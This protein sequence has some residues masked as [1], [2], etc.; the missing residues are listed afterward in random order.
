M[1]I[2]IVKP[3]TAT[4]S[5]STVLRA[6]QRNDDG[7]GIVAITPEGLDIRRGFG[8]DAD[9]TLL[10]AYDALRQY[11][12]IIH[13]RIGTTGAL[14]LRNTHPFPIAHDAWLFHNGTIEIDRNAAPEMCDSYH[15][16][17]ALADAVGDDITA[18]RDPDYLC[19]LET[20]AKPSR[21]VIVDSKGYV[22][23]N[24]A[25]GEWKDGCWYSNDSADVEPADS[26]AAGDKLGFDDLDDAAGRFYG[27]YHQIEPRCFRVETQEDEDRLLADTLAFIG[28]LQK[29]GVDDI[30][31]RCLE[32]PEMAAEA[33]F[34]LVNSRTR[35]ASHT[36][37]T[38]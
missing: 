24:E 27:S 21:L 11:D 16:A 38:T 23:V 13:C 20:Y 6:Y 12:L 18:L 7:W 30:A 22:I 19:D 28:D 33:L 34:L 9:E 32:M 1:C 25:L 31:E 5:L 36:H 8:R 3:A 17:Q 10:D 26:L 29:F 37:A 2:I 35:S 14:D 4:L 15:V